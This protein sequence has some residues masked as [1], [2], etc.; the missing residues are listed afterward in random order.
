[1][2]NGVAT[3]SLDGMLCLTRLIGLIGYIGTRAFFHVA[4][5]NQTMPFLNFGVLFIDRR[6]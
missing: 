5:P 3:E 6:W 4:Q 1:M 2:L